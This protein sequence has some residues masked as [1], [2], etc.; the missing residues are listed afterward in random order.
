MPTEINCGIL[1]VLFECLLVCLVGL[2][3]GWV[4]GCLVCFVG[5]LVAV[6]SGCRQRTCFYLFV[7][8]CFSV[9]NVSLL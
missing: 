2:L 6:V 4:N 1:P 7:C 3:G 8:V 5:L 9:V